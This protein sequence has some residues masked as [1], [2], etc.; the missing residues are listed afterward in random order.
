[1]ISDENVRLLAQIGNDVTWLAENGC[2][3]GV[4]AI[5]AERRR[6][7]QGL[8]YDAL[9]DDRHGVRDLAAMAQRKAH[10]ASVVPENSRVVD[11][12]R[13]YLK[14]AGALAAAAIDRGRPTVTGRLPERPDLVRFRPPDVP[15]ARSCPSCQS[16]G[17]PREGCKDGWHAAWAAQAAEPAQVSE[18]PAHLPGCQYD[19]IP[20]RGGCVGNGP[21]LHGRCVPVPVEGHHVDDHT[22]EGTIGWW[23][24]PAEV[25][26]QAYGTAAGS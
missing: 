19:G 18:I 2:L 6:Q 24:F 22:H 14:E 13:T 9:H 1:M 5:I 10:L 7:V 8:G 25:T 4:A 16:I 20:H 12:P 17:A 21:I 23:R 11:A 26:T 3:A 15:V